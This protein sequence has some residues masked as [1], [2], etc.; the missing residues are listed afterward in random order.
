[1]IAVETGKTFW[2][3]RIISNIITVQSI[4]NVYALL[5]REMRNQ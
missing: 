2:L 5:K 3:V 1:M 4:S